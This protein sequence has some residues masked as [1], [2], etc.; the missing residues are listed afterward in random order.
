MDD[1]GNGGKALQGT[2]GSLSAE[3]LLAIE[4]VWVNDPP[5]FLIPIAAE[6]SAFLT[7]EEDRI[8][9]VGVDCCGWSVENILGAAIISNS[10]IVLTDADLKYQ[11]DGTTLKQIS[12]R[13]VFAEGRVVDSSMPV[14]MPLNDTLIVKISTLHGGVFLRDARSEVVFEDSSTAANNL[15]GGY[16]ASL[17]LSGPLW[18][19]A[20]ALKGIRYKTN[21]NWNSWLGPGGT[22]LQHVVSEVSEWVKS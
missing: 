15:P 18:A 5:T 21:L 11:T 9:I 14:A 8:G 10:S 1:R 12:S 16:A 13:W 2:N 19:V 6:A 7:A 17:Q 20:D 3:I 22:H 4:V